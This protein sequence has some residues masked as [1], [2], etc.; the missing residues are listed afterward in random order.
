MMKAG[1]LGAFG[2]HACSQGV[3]LTWGQ[4]GLSLQTRPTLTMGALCLY[5]RGHGPLWAELTPPHPTHGRGEV[6]VLP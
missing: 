6:P 3:P 5:S 2:G 4:A 1:M